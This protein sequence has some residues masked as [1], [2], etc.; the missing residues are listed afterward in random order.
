MK[1]K[2][3]KYDPAVD[4]APRYIEHEVPFKEKMTMLE[5]IV[6]VH[7]NKEMIAYDYSCHG[8]MCGRCAMMLDG[9]PSLACCTPI[10]NK[11]HTIEPLKGQTIVRDLIVDKTDYHN[12]L[13]QHSVRIRIEPIK[14]EEINTYDA[15]A[16]ATIY[17]IVNCT[18]CGVCDAACPAMAQKPGQY[19]G[20]STMLAISLRHL[21]SYDQGDRVL[22]AVSNGLYHCIMCGQCTK[23]CQRYEIDHLKQWNMLRD[24]AVKAGLKP[25]YAK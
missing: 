17:D 20:P 13:S 10:T 15:A 7:E 14:K 6:W 25:S 8:R 19:A 24:A 18:R 2:I 9:V 12:R 4:A 21:D 3:F 1:I 23:V 11:D 22:E 5:V 16:A